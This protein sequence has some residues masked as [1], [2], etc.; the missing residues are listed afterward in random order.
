MAVE[1]VDCQKEGFSEGTTASTTVKILSNP[2]QH[3]L[4]ELITLNWAR[5]YN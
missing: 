3:T 4:W 5:G 1:I 2:T